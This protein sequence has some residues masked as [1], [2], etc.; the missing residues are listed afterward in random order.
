MKIDIQ[1]SLVFDFVYEFLN[2]IKEN[3]MK[4]LIMVT[5]MNLCQENIPSD[6]LKTCA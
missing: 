6:P 5:F 3:S 2:L 4:E 1:F